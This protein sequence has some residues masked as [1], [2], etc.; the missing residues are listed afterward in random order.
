MM[1][2]Y[3]QN[4][5][6]RYDYSSFGLS[7]S[8]PRG[9]SLLTLFLQSSRSVLCFFF[10]FGSRFLSSCQ[11]SRWGAAPNARCCVGQGLPLISVGASDRPEQ[12]ELVVHPR[13][14]RKALAAPQSYGKA[15]RRRTLQ[16]SISGQDTRPSTERPEFLCSQPIAA[17]I[18]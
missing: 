15:L 10:F 4:L 9:G 8:S 18:W 2:L 12:L 14:T 7:H 17:P 1:K 16:L 5:Q 3:H 13:F 11:H 6:Q